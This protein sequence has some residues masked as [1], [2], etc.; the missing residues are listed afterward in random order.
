MTKDERADQWITKCLEELEAMGN[1]Y[2]LEF[3]PTLIGN[4]PVIHWAG[5]SGVVNFDMTIRDRLG[6]DDILGFDYRA[7]M[8]LKEL[9]KWIA[10]YAAITHDGIL[11]ALKDRVFQRRSL[12][13]NGAVNLPFKVVAPDWVIKEEREEQEEQ[14]LADR[15]RRMADR[16]I[17]SAIDFELEATVDSGAVKRA[18]KDTWLEK[19]Y[20]RLIVDD[21]EGDNLLEIG[22]R[23]GFFMKKVVIPDLEALLDDG[24]LISYADPRRMPSV[25]YVSYTQLHELN[26]TLQHLIQKNLKKDALDF[27]ASLFIY[28]EK[29]RTP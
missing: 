19:C 4:I 15:L 9:A 11:S 10:D 13:P 18:V 3:A 16:W 8:F 12:K 26:A 21:P 28:V 2:D 24:Y 1:K 17:A 20:V 22:T 6:E 29:R 14:L 23:A 7:G 27:N 5:T 25:R